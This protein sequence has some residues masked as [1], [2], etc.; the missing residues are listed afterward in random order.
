MRSRHAQLSRPASVSSATFLICAIAAL[1]P[2]ILVGRSSV[3][4][5]SSPTGVSAGSIWL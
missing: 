5:L 1:A 2:A 3:A 4:S